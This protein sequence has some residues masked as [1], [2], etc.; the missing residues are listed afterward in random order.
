MAQWT[1][2]RGLDIAA[3]LHRTRP[4]LWAQLNARIG[5]TP[6]ELER[7]RAAA[8]TIA[9][10]FDPETGLFEQFAGYFA[11]DDIQ[12]PDAA[13][14][15]S[16]ESFL[17]KP[18]LQQSQL[19]KQADVVALL[20]L[21]PEVFPP[22]TAA[23][24]FRY[25]ERRCTHDSSLSPAF[26]GLV[27]ARLGE[28]ETAL[29]YFRQAASIDLSDTISQQD[30][31]LHMATLG[32]MWMLVVFGFLGVGLAPDHLVVDPVA[33]P[34]G[35]RR[36]SAALQWRGRRLRITA[37]QQRRLIDVTLLSGAPARV[38]VGGRLHTLRSDDPVQVDWHTAVPT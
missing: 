31:G 10:G 13:S 17:G 5:V 7:W 33:L 36:L 32:G 29:R 16:A 6:A 14:T 26:H 22:G 12:L 4:D 23:A 30:G 37:D 34:R 35:W 9:T 1:I 15:G 25:Y 24:N 8:D 3:Q 27:A 38:S 20:A 19:I 18:R 21:L 2:R 28:S 11:R